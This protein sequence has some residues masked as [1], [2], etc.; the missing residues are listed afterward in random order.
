MDRIIRAFTIDDLEPVNRC[1]DIIK[2]AEVYYK[3]PLKNL[4]L[5]APLE[6][7]YEVADVEEPIGQWIAN[8]PRPG[9]VAACLPPRERVRKK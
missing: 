4:E 3:V 1:A 8:V 7:L 2:K 9:D 5:K 6:K